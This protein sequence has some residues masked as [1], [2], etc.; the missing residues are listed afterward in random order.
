MDCDHL[1]DG[2]W[3]PARRDHMTERDGRTALVLAVPVEECRACGETWLT[4]EIAKH[5]DS[6]FNELLRS[7]AQNSRIHWDQ[8]HAA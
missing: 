7:G 4:I 5:L 3:R 1:D 2:Q 8:S 6:L